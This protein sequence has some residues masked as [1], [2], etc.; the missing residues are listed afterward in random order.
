[1][2]K[3]FATRGSFWLSLIGIGLAI[4]LLIRTSIPQGI[5]E[6]LVK[7]PLKPVDTRLAGSGLVESLGDNTRISSVIAGVVSGVFTEVGKPV[8]KG[9]VL[10][11]LDT[12]IADS[13]LEIARTSLKVAQADLDRLQ[14]IVDRLQGVEDRRAVSEAELESRLSELEVARAQVTNAKALVDSAET[15]LRMLTVKSPIEATVLQVN[16]RLGE[17]TSPGSNPPPILLGNT[18]ELQIRAELDEEL[19]GELPPQPRAVGFVR[20]IG[21]KG[22]ELE[23]I[24]VEPLIVPKRNLS[25]TPG[26]RVDTRVFQVLFRPVNPVDNQRLLIGQQLDIFVKDP[27]L[28]EAAPDPDS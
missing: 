24:R 7:P 25:G 10:F 5:P 18:S 13:E 28:A 15:R 9:E 11:A 21:E 12:R 23:F 22:I 4:A 19:A 2:F 16:V 27:N 14:K 26:E 17:F 20:G 3:L 8:K 6:P 1:M